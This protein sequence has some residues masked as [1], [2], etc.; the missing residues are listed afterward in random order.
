MTETRDLRALETEGEMDEE[1]AACNLSKTAPVA[2]Y[3]FLGYDPKIACSHH[4]VQKDWD[5]HRLQAKH[6]NNIVIDD[7]RTCLTL[8]GVV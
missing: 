8:V 5:A 3:A 6:Y 1:Y 7:V 4:Q 2:L